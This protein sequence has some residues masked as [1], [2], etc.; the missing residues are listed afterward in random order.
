MG[1]ISK[2]ILGAFRGKVGTVVG[3]TW[4]GI[5]VMRSNPGPRKGQP[6][7]KQLDQH[8]RFGLMIK[9]LQPVS[10]LLSQ[11]FD[12][13]AIG[14]T[15][16]NKAMSYNLPNAIT[17]S[18]PAYTVNYAMVLLSRGDLPNAGS[19]VVASPASGKLTFSW[20]DNSGTGRAKADDQVFVAAYSEALNRWIY[21]QGIAARN[22]GT[23]T[24]DF[25][26][27]SGKAAQTYIGFVSAD[28]KFVANSLYTGVVNV[29]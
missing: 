1:T 3:S 10:S 15:G 16:I 23:V 19:P 18:Y 9:F 26:S 4:K 22:A 2:G 21:A 6:S 5:S 20:T 17:G 7:Q 24:L 8:A 28:G 12:K 25:S 14:M 29:L 27:F 11:T 13:V